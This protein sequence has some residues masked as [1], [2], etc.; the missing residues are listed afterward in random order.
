MRKDALAHL[1]HSKD[2][3]LIVSKRRRLTFLVPSRRAFVEPCFAPCTTFCIVVVVINSIMRHY[4]ITIPS[5]AS[6]WIEK[7]G[8]H[9]PSFG[10]AA[11]GWPEF[12]FFVDWQYYFAAFLILLHLQGLPNQPEKRCPVS[13]SDSLLATSLPS[14]RH[15]LLNSL[16]YGAENR[17]PI[18]LRSA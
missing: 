11:W 8:S 4:K 3:L 5:R 18:H 12:R 17:A 15:L 13:V 7:N 1:F 6:T 16:W 2:G 14:K 9:P 10:S